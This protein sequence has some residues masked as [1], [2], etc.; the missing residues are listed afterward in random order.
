MAIHRCLEPWKMIF[1]KRSFRVIHIPL[2]HLIMG[3]KAIFPGASAWKM[4]HGHGN[5][6]WR[7]PMFASLDPWDQMSKNLADQLWIFSKCSVA[8]LPSWICYNIRHIHISFFQA[9]PIPF[10]ADAVSEIIY[11]SD[12]V[13]PGPPP[14]SPAYQASW[15][16]HPQHHSYQRRSRHSHSGSW[17][18]LVAE[19]NAR[20]LPQQHAAD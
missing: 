14:Q 2:P 16:K 1:L 19:Q 9:Y 5:P 12:P 10:P 20:I 8:S 3:V 7:Y 13:P 15:Q 4:L 6:L 18:P 17:I 11:K